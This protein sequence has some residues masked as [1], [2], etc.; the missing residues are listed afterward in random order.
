MPWGAL[1]NLRVSALL[2]VSPRSQKVP[3]PP[4]QTQRQGLQGVLWD[5]RLKSHDDAFPKG[6]GM[7][8]SASL[9]PPE[10]PGGLRGRCASPRFRK[11]LRF[12]RFSFLRPCPLT[13]L[14]GPMAHRSDPQRIRAV[15]R[16][17]PQTFRNAS[18]PQGIQGGGSN[19]NSNRCNTFSF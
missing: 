8:R 19:N 15:W 12:L 9:G 5:T 18:P 2:R 10:A 4:A 11:N 16:K 13:L 7:I 1:K 14:Q 3:A 17:T 6:P